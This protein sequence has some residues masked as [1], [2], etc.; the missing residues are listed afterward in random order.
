MAELVTILRKTSAE[1]QVYQT[2]FALL[3][4]ARMGEC[5]VVHARRR[6]SR[7]FTD[8]SFFLLQESLTLILLC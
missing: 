2:K 5:L 7:M 8:L 3:R 1:Q 4:K 6:V